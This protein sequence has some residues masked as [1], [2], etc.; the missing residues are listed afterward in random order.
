MQSISEVEGQ[1]FVMSS[2][3]VVLPLSVR[4]TVEWSCESLVDIARDVG[5]VRA[6]EMKIRELVEEFLHPAWMGSSAG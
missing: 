2:C 3:R 4:G 6:K 1:Y 5:E